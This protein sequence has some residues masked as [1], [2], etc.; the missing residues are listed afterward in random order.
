MVVK[1]WILSFFMNPDIRVAHGPN[2]GGGSVSSFLRH[3]RWVI[4]NE[5]RGQR[6]CAVLPVTTP[7]VYDIALIS[8]SWT[9]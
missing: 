4:P 3:E 1:P 5:S 8:A 9:E 7:R 6:D 2:D